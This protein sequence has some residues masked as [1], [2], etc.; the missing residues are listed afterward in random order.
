MSDTYQAIFD[1]VRS[2]IS[3]AHPGQILEQYLSSCFDSSWQN[4]AA[5]AFSEFAYAATRPSSYLPVKVL[6]D[7]N[8]WCC[9][10][11]WPKDSDLMEQLVAFGDTPDKACLEFDKIWLNGEK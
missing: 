4:H 11:H 8:A 3:A 9:S 5:N 6:R 1:A 10:L 2:R 7:G